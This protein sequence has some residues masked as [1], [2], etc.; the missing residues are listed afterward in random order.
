MDDHVSPQLLHTNEP[1]VVNWLF[2]VASEHPTFSGG[3]SLSVV[4]HWFPSKCRMGNVSPLV[5]SAKLQIICGLKT[6]SPALM[7][8]LR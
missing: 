6:S 7:V 4:I 1:S 2:L 3:R 5:H 8:V